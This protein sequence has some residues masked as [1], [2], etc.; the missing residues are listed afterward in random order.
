[1]H[2]IVKTIALSAI[3]GSTSLLASDGVFLLTEGPDQMPQRV[4]LDT[5]PTLRVNDHGYVQDDNDRFLLGWNINMGM[6]FD[7]MNWD[8]SR[9]NLSLVRYLDSHCPTMQTNFLNTQFILPLDDPI[10]VSYSHQWQVI[11]NM[12]LSHDLIGHFVKDAPETWFVSLNVPDAMDINMSVRRDNAGGSAID[13]INPIILNF[14]VSHYLMDVD[15]MPVPRSLY[16]QWDPAKTSA[17]DQY[18]SLDFGPMGLSTSTRQESSAD[19]GVDQSYQDGSIPSTPVSARVD[20]S[21][22]FYTKYADGSEQ[23]SFELGYMS[24]GT[25][26]GQM[27]VRAALDVA[28]QTSVNAI[29]SAP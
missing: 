24:L 19:F 23:P 7:P 3:L 14:D 28:T 26:P 16:I 21:G 4:V 8:M 29:F 5:S 1:M 18:F 13:A 22:M 2:N 15:G 25:M 12:G 6:P 20:A 9:N 11:D 17:Y 27:V 10:G